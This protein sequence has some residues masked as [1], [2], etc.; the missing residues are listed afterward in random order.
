MKKRSKL[1]ATIVASVMC[2]G[3]IVYG[4][5]ALTTVSFALNS[6]FSFDANGVY[7]GVS[8]QVYTGATSTDLEPLTT[9]DSYTLNEVKNFTAKEDGTPDGTKSQETIAAWEPANVTLDEIKP[10]LLYEVKFKNYAPYDIM[11]IPTNNTASVEGATIT[12][13]KDD[14]TIIASGEIGTYKLMVEITKFLEDIEQTTVNISFAM[15]K[16]V[17]NEKFFDFNETIGRITGLNT[18]TYTAETAPET[19][20]IPATINGVEVK[21][22]ATKGYGVGTPTFNFS[23]KTKNIIIQAKIDSIPNSGFYGCSSLVSVILPSSL[24]N[25]G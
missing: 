18:E 7:V 8:G 9:D 17:S 13:S 22:L 25:I 21:S 3:L 5:Y 6:S 16:I 12:E 15:E 19:L 24:K 11:I 4:V 23:D 10:Y 14:I 2:L 20:V 1:I